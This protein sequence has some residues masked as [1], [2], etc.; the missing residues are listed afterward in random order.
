MSKEMSIARRSMFTHIEHE[1]R[2]WYDERWDHT[3]PLPHVLQSLFV[4]FSVLNNKK[5]WEGEYPSFADGHIVFSLITET[6]E[7]VMKVAPDLGIMLQ[8][9]GIA[10]NFYRMRL[11]EAAAPQPTSTSSSSSSASTS[12]SVPP[13]S[14]SAST[15]SSSGVIGGGEPPRVNVVNID[16]DPIEEEDCD[17]R[18]IRHHHPALVIVKDEEE[19]E[20]NPVL[21]TPPR[22][23]YALR[24]PIPPGAPYFKRQRK[25]H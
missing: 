12:S 8:G 7:D 15:S 9:C 20:I 10:F 18:I 2:F 1:I 22:I 13:A 3:K 6:H 16:A 25:F 24:H 11:E 23:P 5:N 19:D 21:H 14:S 4:K 17:V